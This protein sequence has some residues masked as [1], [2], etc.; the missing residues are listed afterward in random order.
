MDCAQMAMSVRKIEC[1]FFLHHAQIMCAYSSLNATGNAPDCANPY[2]LQTVLREGMNYSGMVISDN[3]AIE[4]VWAT[5]QWAPDATHAAADC[6]NAGCDNDLGG[7]E[8]V[9]TLLV[10]TCML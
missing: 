2:L 8:Q 7:D 10:I 4:M 5:H 6:M 3:G 1:F 9:S